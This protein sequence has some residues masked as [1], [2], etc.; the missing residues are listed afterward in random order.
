MSNERDTQRPTQVVINI[1]LENDAFELDGV[2]EVA[3]ILR[4]LAKTI[5]DSAGQDTPV[6]RDLQPWSGQ[7]TDHYGN[8]CGSCVI[9]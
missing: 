2:G 7:L 4:R 6:G 9:E 3:R 8:R 1:D 5:E